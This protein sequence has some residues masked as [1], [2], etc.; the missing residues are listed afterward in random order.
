MDHVDAWYVR[1]KQARKA[2]ASHV[3]CTFPRLANLHDGATILFCCFAAR[4]GRRAG[5]GR[6][7]LEHVRH[8]LDE[9]STVDQLDS[10]SNVDEV[11]IE[12]TTS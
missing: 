9:N 8:V 4:G 7:G 11:F 6:F 1:L 2:S 5:L 3:Q 12:E 10:R